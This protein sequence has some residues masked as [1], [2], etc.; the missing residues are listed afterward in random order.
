[1]NGL[2]YLVTITL[3]L[4]WLIAFFILDAGEMV[5]ILLVMAIGIVLFKLYQEESSY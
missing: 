3:I 1:M 4:S 2:I 5:H